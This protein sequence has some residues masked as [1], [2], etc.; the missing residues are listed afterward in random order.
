[1]ASSTNVT[2]ETSPKKRKLPSESDSEYSNQSMPTI[3]VRIVE[4]I[5]NVNFADLIGGAQ[6]Q[7]LQREIGELVPPEALMTKLFDSLY[8]KLQVRR[9]PSYLTP[10]ANV[11]SFVSH[12]LECVIYH[13]TVELELESRAILILPEEELNLTSEQLLLKL[14]G[15]ADYLVVHSNGS[16]YERLVVIEVKRAIDD[17]IKQCLLCAKNSYHANSEKRKIYCF[18]TDAAHWRLITYN[19]GDNG[20]SV[21]QMFPQKALMIEDMVSADSKELWRSLCG[22][23]IG[24]VYS[25]MKK[26]MSNCTKKI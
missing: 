13:L 11:T 18:T 22:S 4:K 1:M 2:L 16:N 7:N 20:E 25:V 10:E 6:T 15:K 26:V 9:Y 21:I 8:E 24:M 5:L 19:E 3:D 12:I 17:G 14:T 23:G